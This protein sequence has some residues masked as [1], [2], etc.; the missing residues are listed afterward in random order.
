MSYLRTDR[1]SFSVA[2]GSKGDCTAAV[3]RL[4]RHRCMLIRQAF[5]SFYLFVIASSGLV[6]GLSWM[7]DS[8]SAKRSLMSHK[9]MTIGLQERRGVGLAIQARRWRRKSAPPSLHS[10]RRLARRYRYSVDSYND[11]TRMR[12]FKPCA[13]PVSGVENRPET[14]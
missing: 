8:F 11:S 7:S 10:A 12:S 4:V 5:P 13:P 1:A 6:T 14:P 2:L 9:Q 3:W